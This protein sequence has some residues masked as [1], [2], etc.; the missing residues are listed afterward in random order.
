MSVCFKDSAHSEGD[1][2][3]WNAFTSFHICSTAWKQP[4]LP[5]LSCSSLCISA[6][7]AAHASSESPAFSR[8][9]AECKLASHLLLP[10]GSPDWK[11]R[12]W[13][14]SVRSCVCHHP[15]AQPAQGTG[16]ALKADSLFHCNSENL[17]HSTILL[18]SA[19]PHS[20]QGV[21]DPT[22]SYSPCGPLKGTY[23][24]H[25]CVSSAAISSLC[26]CSFLF[27]LSSEVQSSKPFY[28]KIS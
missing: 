16:C 7:R 20:H 15:S 26:S 8:L 13:A 21:S 4:L 5:F 28:L 27:H 25:P 1:G 12:R 22:S 3:S 14:L 10:P 17:N 23:G 11:H 2:F 18:L 24:E 6:A 19:S 9:K